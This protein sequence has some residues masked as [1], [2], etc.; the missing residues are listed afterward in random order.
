MDVAPGAAS[1]EARSRNAS[2]QPGL[3]DAAFSR[4]EHGLALAALRNFPAL[5]QMPKLHFPTDQRRHFASRVRFQFGLGC[6]QHRVQ[7]AR[8]RNPLQGPKAECAH[9]KTL[10]HETQRGRAD[11][12]RIRAG[13]RLDSSREIGCLTDRMIDIAATGSH[14]PDHHEAR[15]D[16]DSSLD[17]GLAPRFARRVERAHTG[18]DGESCEDGTLRI[19]VMRH[20]VAENGDDAVA[21]ILIDVAAIPGD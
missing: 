10:A 13:L 4:H 14:R 3:A 19:V 6:A 2:Q 21:D 11:A 9:L 7:L 8:R 5:E 18:D 16:S 15:I 17:A 20:G 12:D 1:G